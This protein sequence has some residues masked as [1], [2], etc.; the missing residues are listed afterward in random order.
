MRIWMLKFGFKPL[1]PKF[2]L[3]PDLG[4]V[5]SVF[6]TVKLRFRKYC[7]AWN[8]SVTWFKPDAHKATAHNFVQGKIIIALV[9]MV[10]LTLGTL[11]HACSPHY[12]SGQRQQK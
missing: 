9:D 6:L 5:L 8:R 3:K 2:K 1:G 10:Q 7:R 12:L 11:G 4:L